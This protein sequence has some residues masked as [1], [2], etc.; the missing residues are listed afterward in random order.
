M[1]LN[2][3]G[4]MVDYRRI[5]SGHVQVYNL[6]CVYSVVQYVQASHICV[7]N[8]WPSCVI[9]HLCVY[10]MLTPAHMCTVFISDL[11]LCVCRQLLMRFTP[12][13]PT[14]PHV[15][16]VSTNDLFSCML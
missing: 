14:H 6:C 16:W 1:I 15:M 7:Q 2:L 4:G 9:T 5:I 3:V 8:V 12:S 11:A 13:T 10:C